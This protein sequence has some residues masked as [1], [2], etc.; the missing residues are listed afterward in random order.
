M[1]R[2]PN[3]TG[4]NDQGWL[5]W[6]SAEKQWASPSRRAWE[7]LEGDEKWLYDYTYRAA[8]LCLE[9]DEQRRK[10]GA[11]SKDKDK[12][13]AVCLPH[14]LAHSEVSN[15]ERRI[16][17]WRLLGQHQQN[18]ILQQLQAPRQPSI[19]PRLR[20]RLSPPALQLPEARGQLCDR[21]RKLLVWTAE[22]QA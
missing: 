20:L 15:G 22:S 6:D 17:E 8:D 13:Y 18:Q 14:L 10:E 5:A 2:E 9:Y 19:L 7:K 1:S 21:H 4:W 11:K 12:T 3:A 16:A